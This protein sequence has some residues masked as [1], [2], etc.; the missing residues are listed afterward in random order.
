M[1]GASSRLYDEGRQ[2]PLQFGQDERIAV[3]CGL[4]RLPKEAP[5][6]LRAWVERSYNLQHWAELPRGGIGTSFG[7]RATPQG[8]CMRSS[9]PN[10]SGRCRPS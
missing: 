10:W 7:S 8:T 4:A 5:M 9:C 3:P 1:I 6:P 2:R